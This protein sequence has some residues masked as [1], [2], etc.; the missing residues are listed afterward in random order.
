[1]DAEWRAS[2][3]SK[4]G[5][6]YARLCDESKGV[7]EQERNRNR[8]MNSLALKEWGK[9]KNGL[10][11]KIQILDGVVNGVW[12]LGG[13]GG[14]YARLV[15]RFER[16]VDGVCE[17]EEE[18]KDGGEIISEGMFVEDLDTAWKEDLDGIVR[19]LERWQ[20]QMRGISDGLR[21]E[22]AD[23][24]GDGEGGDSLGRM[25]D[26]AG[27]LID[28]MLTEIGMMEEMEREALAREE[29]W[30]EKMIKDGDE[31]D[32][33]GGGGRVRAGAIWRSK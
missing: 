1:M 5:E 25:L 18:R 21:S 2:A 22:R 26:G 29:V 23:G 7:V 16:W 13:A 30:I 12:G 4:L 6:R 8:K 15:R 27:T 9:A 19:K 17:I 20:D 3:K 31:D 10:E 33:M 32:E 14:R 24:D 28:D 11:D